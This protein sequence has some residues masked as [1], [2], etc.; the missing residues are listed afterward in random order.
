MSK[1]L[2]KYFN[3]LYEALVFAA[4]AYFTVKKQ[5]TVNNF[6]PLYEALVFAAPRRV[7]ISDISPMNFNPLYEALVFAALIV[8]IHLNNQIL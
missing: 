1:S 5:F 6:N 7:R 8:I 3:P 4:P 2:W